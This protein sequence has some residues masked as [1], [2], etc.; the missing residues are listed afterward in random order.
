MNMKNKEGSKR[1]SKPL[2]SVKEIQYTNTNADTD[3]VTLPIG[4]YL[5]LVLVYTDELSQ[6]K[7]VYEYIFDS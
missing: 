6:E 7:N 5:L 2:K 1:G 4:D 3:S